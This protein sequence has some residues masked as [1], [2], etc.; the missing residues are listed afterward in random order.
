MYLNA[1]SIKSKLN[2]LEI[3]ARE[4]NPDLI[5]VTE[6][7][8]SSEITNSEL[9]IENYFI[10]PSLR[11]DR[12]DTSNGIGGGLLVYVK[13]GLK[14][15][16]VD[17][18]VDFN[19][20]CRFNVLS[21]DNKVDFNV[22]LIYRSPNSKSANNELLYSLL[23][24]STCNNLIVGDFN[25]PNIDWSTYSGD[26][27]TKD[28]LDI[29]QDRFL[30]QKIDFP[31]RGQNILDLALTD[32]PE[33]FLN[34]EN[35]GPIKNSDHDVIMFE[36]ISSR[37]RST[38]QC[39]LIE[40]WHNANVN[41]IKKQLKSFHQLTDKKLSSDMYYNSF[42]ECVED[43]IKKFVP[44]KPRR[45]RNKPKWMTR[46][47]LQLTRQKQRKYKIYCENR[48]N[49]NYSA[50][51]KCENACRKAVRN[52]KR[53][54][55]LKIA[56]NS[57]EKQFNAYL[58]SKM[59]CR[60]NVGPLKINNETIFDD[61]RIAEH[62]NVYFAS[63]FSSQNIE[64]LEN[65]TN[66]EFESITDIL[67]DDKDV[68]QVINDIKDG[69]SGPDNISVKFLKTYVNEVSPILREI[70]RKSLDSGSLPEQWKKANVTAV[71]K[72]GSKFEPSNYR[73]ISLTS[74][75]C[76]ILETLMRKKVIEH[77]I[78]NKLLKSSQH[79]FLKG[80]SCC[81]NLLE[82]FE[83]ITKNFD[84]GKAMDIIYLDFSK[85]F[86]K[87]PYKQLLS[88]IKSFGIEGKLFNWLEDWLN[89]RMQRVVL[90]G[91]SSNWQDVL[92]GIPQGSVI[93]PLLFLIYI[94]DI[95][96][97][98][99]LIDL[100]SKFADDTKLCKT[101][102][103]NSDRQELQQ[104]LDC[105]VQWSEKHGMAFNASKCK[106][107]HVGKNNPRFEYKINGIIVKETDSEKDVGV[108]YTPNLKP[109]LQCE[110]AA[111]KAN[112]MLGQINRC[113]QFKDKEIFLNLYKRYV[114][115]HMEFSTPAWNPWMAKD[116][117]LLE[118][119]QERAVRQ[120]Q[121]LKGRTYEEKLSELNLTTLSERRKRADM[122]E[123]FKIIRGH[124]NVEKSTW[125]QNVRNDG[126]Q[127]RNSSIPDNL[128]KTQS[129]TDIRKNFFSVRVINSWNELPN[130]L[131]TD[132]SVKNFKRNYDKL[133][134]KR[135]AV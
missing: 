92:S 85:A 76:K 30:T 23:R 115:V 112:S 102:K 25:Y 122:I 66:N 34:I 64:N 6:S 48:S 35:L 60:T 81:T 130:D 1:R 36:I 10:D 44:K 51:K 124:N 88:K 14:I 8:C 74:V 126:T 125:F 62:L 82:F 111:K 9:S 116:I 133:C 37:S 20:Y 43:C 97:A 103:D 58:K 121:G 132:S 99:E 131:K 119:I 24:T 123:T 31:T 45:S 86:D 118:K 16:T 46:K 96:E 29:I 128:K 94:N 106:V 28:F 54:F 61:K 2:E 78:E 101:V 7:W 33:R 13:N 104:T 27:K 49:E 100:L 15:L 93:G 53:K 79:G 59:K 57:N 50:Y 127:T 26:S 38:E 117:D 18:T 120:I 55:E 52:A 11:Q 89:N 70:Y 72:K 3:L 108:I 135:P 47:V 73:P 63:V 32:C 19:Q 67:I 68:K 91:E 56:N 69:A 109:S 129:K 12:K 80:K 39:D 71:H 114:R 42:K 5:L 98:A 65:T 21:D 105:L 17:N 90:N 40:D 41:E 83:H 113:F 134:A 4:N 87:V 75:P 110:K 22:T 77:I 95:D 107:L 84:E